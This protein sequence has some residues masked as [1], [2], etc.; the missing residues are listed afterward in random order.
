[1]A[2][3]VKHVFPRELIVMKYLESKSFRKAICVMLL[4]LM[5]FDGYR[6]ARDSN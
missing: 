2:N 4:F 5:A 3:A 6:D 1:L